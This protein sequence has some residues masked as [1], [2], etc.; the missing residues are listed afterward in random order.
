M[1]PLSSWVNS[2]PI[3]VITLPR[4]LETAG[5]VASLLL[6][7]WMVDK[8]VYIITDN[9][10]RIKRHY[11]KDIPA[12]FFL[13]RNWILSPTTIKSD[14]VIVEK[15]DWLSSEMFEALQASSVKQ[16]YTYG[17]QT[18]LSDQ[19][20][21]FLISYPRPYLTLNWE[22]PTIRYHLVRSEDETQALL[23]LMG[24]L[25]TSPDED[26]IVVTSNPAGYHNSLGSNLQSCNAIV[27]VYQPENEVTPATLSQASSNNGGNKVSA[28][29][30]SPRR[31][32]PPVISTGNQRV[33][34]KIIPAG[35]L[36]KYKGTIKG[37][38]NIHVVD[39]VDPIS[40]LSWFDNCIYLFDNYI[41]SGVT[42]IVVYWYI[43][44]D[45]NLTDSDRVASYQQ[46]VEQLTNRQRI[47]SQMIQGSL[48][49]GYSGQLTV[50]T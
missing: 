50:R 25:I 28:H 24:N 45:S 26:N 4:I 34:A 40:F 6:E 47:Y 46:T 32:N 39:P 30:F 9:P 37:V 8:T 33:S 35:E 15:L 41:N 1:Y 16:I 44:G 20:A 43:M 19:Q 3:T 48:T 12:E 49:I 42:E 18:F 7:P 38:S 27:E 5:L 23:N 17:Y 13:G 21:S 10:G 36:T 2:N 29:L 14:Y 31:T 11:G 22:G